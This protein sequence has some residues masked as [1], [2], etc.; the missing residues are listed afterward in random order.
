LPTSTSTLKSRLDDSQ[1]LAKVLRDD[2][3]HD[4]IRD[5]SAAFSAED[6]EDLETLIQ[7]AKGMEAYSPDY[8]QAVADAARQAAAPSSNIQ[9]AQ[10][11]ALTLQSSSGQPNSRLVQHSDAMGYNMEPSI[12]QSVSGVQEGQTPALNEQMASGQSNTGLFPQ[13]Q[14]PGYGLQLSSG[15]P[16]DRP[17]NFAQPLGFPGITPLSQA[18]YNVV[19][20]TIRHSVLLEGPGVPAVEGSSGIPQS[21]S[22]NVP[23]GAEYPERSQVNAGPK[24]SP[25]DLTEDSDEEKVLPS[26]ATLESKRHF[27]DLTME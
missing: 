3:R 25:I 23:V 10:A 18:Q 16:N 19:Q 4:L 27:V 2:C 5:M 14:A 21:R 17:F 22:G 26:S 11:P 6:Y 24:A 1:K 12:G 7:K 15:N 9:Q 8:E 13:G 20:R